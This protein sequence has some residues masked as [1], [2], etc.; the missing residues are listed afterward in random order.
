M[1][2][3]ALPIR[4]VS[5]LHARWEDR[6]DGVPGAFVLVVVL[7]DGAEELVAVA[8]VRDVEALIPLILVAREAYLDLERAAVVVGGVSVPVRVGREST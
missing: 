2:T 8:D 4:Q 3:A 6:G 1:T 7:D 5:Q